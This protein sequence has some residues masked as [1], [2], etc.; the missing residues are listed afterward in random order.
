MPAMWLS[1]APL[2]LR[3]CCCK[4]SLVGFDRQVLTIGPVV[5]SGAH[6]VLP[7]VLMAS[8]TPLLLS[9]LICK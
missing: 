2:N 6:A 4:H 8:I 9:L 3:G 5:V 1:H 7:D